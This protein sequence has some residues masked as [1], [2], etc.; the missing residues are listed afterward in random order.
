MDLGQ[1]IQLLMDFEF[2]WL[3]VASV[4]VFLLI[5]W[6]APVVDVPK[7]VESA[8]ELPNPEPLAQLPAPPPAPPPPDTARVAERPAQAITGSRAVRN[9]EIDQLPATMPRKHFPIVSQMLVR[10]V[11]TRDIGRIVEDRYNI[12]GL[13][14]APV[15]FVAPRGEAAALG[16]VCIPKSELQAVR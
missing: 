5:L 16:Y 1:L 14:E 9:G 4:V 12:C 11:T 10:H 6:V 8:P 3:C 13:D 7:A 15:R 2:W